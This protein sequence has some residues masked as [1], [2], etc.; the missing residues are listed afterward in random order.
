MLFYDNSDYFYLNIEFFIL[1]GFYV[2]SD[3]D[4]R[5]RWIFSGFDLRFTIQENSIHYIKLLLHLIRA[6]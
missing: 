2:N 5:N 4:Q 3:K 6:I 1:Y